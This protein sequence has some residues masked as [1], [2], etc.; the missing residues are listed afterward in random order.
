MAL[1]SLV[2]A[3]TFNDMQ[4]VVMIFLMITAA[5]MMSYLRLLGKIGS[6]INS[7]LEVVLAIVSIFVPE[8][9]VLLPVA[10]YE[11]YTDRQIV[12]GLISVVSYTGLMT[13]DHGLLMRDN[14]LLLIIT[15]LA[16]YLSL[17]SEL[18][19]R[20]ETDNRRIRDESEI[21]KEKLNDRNKSLLIEQDK[22]I[23]T[24]QLAERNRIAREIHDNVGHMLSRSLLQVGAMM[25]VH[26]DEP[27]AEELSGLRTT[28]DTAMNNIRESVH[29][30]RDESIDI[31]MA[32]A[33]MTEA[34]SEKFDTHVECDVESAYMPKDIKYATI[35]I[36]KEAVSNIMK[37][38]QS[39]TVD[40]KVDEHPSMY[41]IIVH[42]HGSL[43]DASEVMEDID[44]SSGSGMGL[45]NIR[46][47]AEKLGG[48]ARF[49]GGNGFR[50]FVRIPKRS[51]PDSD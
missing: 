14:I 17:N 16:V 29:D 4:L 13:N 5:F 7:V 51:T 3:N 1:M 6:R 20:M 21:K 18:V 19:E 49:S 23:Y 8:A 46:L 30:L 37:Y 36:I 32:I 40:I 15:V 43:Q 25:V 31:G 9:A 39:D 2:I 27:V 35:N 24:A 34:L 12:A 48:Q 22:N 47:R 45:E 33:D 44:I 26:K 50:V 11:M 41:Q 38:S 10:V 42:D 28:L